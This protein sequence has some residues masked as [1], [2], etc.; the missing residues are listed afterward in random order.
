MGITM[1]C[2]R[3]HCIILFGEKIG[4]TVKLEVLGQ[5]LL[6][7]KLVDLEIFLDKPS[8]DLSAIIRLFLVLYHH[9]AD[10]TKLLKYFRTNDGEIQ[11]AAK[12]QLEACI[13]SVSDWMLRNRLKLNE[14]KAEFIL[15]GTSQ[16][17]SK[18]VFYAI[19]VN[20]NVI[21]ASPI[22]HDLGVLLE[23]NSK[24]KIRLQIL[25]KCHSNGYII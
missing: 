13:T 20:G 23:V 9:F 4:L 21:K 2:V 12:S 11:F 8:K 5:N 1:G 17:L 3:C 14:G 6:T 16:Q 24:G 10:D 7:F 19:T 25:A 15:F 22:V 18:V